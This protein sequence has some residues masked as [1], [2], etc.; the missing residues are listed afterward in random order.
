ME[1]IIAYIEECLREARYNTKKATINTYYQRA[2]GAVYAYTLLHHDTQE[3]CDLWDDNYRPQFE[4]E[5]FKA[6]RREL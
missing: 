6:E 4:E 2:Y 3:I 1:K 5:L